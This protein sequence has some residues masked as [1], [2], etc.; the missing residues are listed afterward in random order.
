MKKH[1]LGDRF[2][3]SRARDSIILSLLSLEDF[4]AHKLEGR[5]LDLIF[6]SIHR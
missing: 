5:M 6:R 2:P 1:Q 4:L 3:E